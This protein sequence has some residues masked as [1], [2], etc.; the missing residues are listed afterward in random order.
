MGACL[1][2]DVFGD[3]IVILQVLVNSSEPAGAALCPGVPGRGRRAQSQEEHSGSTGGA[4]G[5]AGGPGRGTHS[6][7]ASKSPSPQR[8]P[9]APAPSAFWC[10]QPPSL[11]LPAPREPFPQLCPW[12]RLTPFVAVVAWWSCCPSSLPSQ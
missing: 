3:G 7:S 6:L 12:A 4:V 2:D 1:W 9:I 11:A 10:Q 8:A 5:A